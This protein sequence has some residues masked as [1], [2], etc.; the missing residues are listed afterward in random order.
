MGALY[1]AGMELAPRKVRRKP[2]L[3]GVGF[4]ML[5]FTGADEI[6]IPALQLSEKPEKKPLSSHLYSLA[7]HVVYGLAAGTVYRAL[8]RAL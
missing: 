4:G 5:L 8:R 7:S 1:G 3:A 2:E 6:A